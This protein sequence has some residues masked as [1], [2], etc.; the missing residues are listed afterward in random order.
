[1]QILVDDVSK[2]FA[3]AIALENVTF[4]IRSGSIHGLVGENGAGKST[5]GKVVGAILQP[6]GG[7][8]IYDGDGSSVSSLREAIERGI[9]VVQQELILCPELSVA[10]NVYLGRET[11]K[12]GFLRSQA[13]LR[14]FNQLRDQ[15]GFNLDGNAKVG[16]LSI[17]DQQ[18]VEIL[19]AL[20]RNAR[21]IV[22]DE[23]T[24]SLTPTEIEHLHQVV[25]NLAKDRKTT[26]IYVS[27][28]LDHILS[29]CDAV[30]VLRNGKHV[31]TGPTADETQASL[32]TAMLGRELADVYP[33]KKAPPPNSAIKLSTSGL[34]KRRKFED[35][36][37]QVK[38]GEIVGIAGLV[39]SGRSEVLRTI[40]G[41]DEFQSGGVAIDGR[42]VGRY[43]PITAMH[44]GLGMVPES[45]REQGL[46][47][48][49]SIAENISLVS[50]GEL[51]PFGF[52]NRRKEAEEI[53]KWAGRLNIK[54]ASTDAL[55]S[56]L[57]G[58]NQQKVLFAKWLAGNPSIML[59]DEPTRG[60]DI[61][62]KSE[63]YN[64][65]AEL[66]ERGMAILIVSSEIEEL[67]GLCHR[68]YIMREGRIVGEKSTDE[69]E[70]GAILRE[71]L[72]VFESD[73]HSNR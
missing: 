13:N 68:I 26:F 51:R 37:I 33:P 47:L 6:S 30:T 61:G 29:T 12:L 28:F 16:S 32:A 15:L 71:C 17:A 22:L 31:R 59:L 58:G 41:A 7:R 56:S 42:P 36:N 10:A 52:V 67:V 5:L 43:T 3:G 72:G 64:L 9:A 49:H 55:V 19:K 69:I 48:E 73:L 60:V 21:L 27:H 57:S 4:E 46:F 62:A 70:I 11:T 63:I 50:F 1:M 38:A 39:G 54:C 40:F 18:Q 53:R 24:S 34:T 8:V 35:I 14:E 66:A 65:I 45:R 20:S 2:H 25:K 44:N 23:P